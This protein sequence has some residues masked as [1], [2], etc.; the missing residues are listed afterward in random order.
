MRRKEA[1]TAGKF[2]RLGEVLVGL[3]G[4]AD[5]EIGGELYAGER[6]AGVFDVP[7]RRFRIVFA[8]HGGKCAR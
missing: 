4:E 8:P 7:Q 2:H 3:V 5:D 1:D 6:C